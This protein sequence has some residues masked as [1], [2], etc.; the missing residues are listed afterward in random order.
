M[1]PPFL[2]MPMPAY[3]DFHAATPSPIFAIRCRFAIILLPV[4]MRVA[5][6]YAAFFDFA[7]AM[8]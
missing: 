7:E 4:M 8:Q 2:L 6:F 1:M 3:A 5:M